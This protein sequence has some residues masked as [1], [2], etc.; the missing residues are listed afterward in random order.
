VK[1]FHVH[2]HADDIETSVK[3]YTTLFGA[4][5]TKHKPDYAKWMLD[6]PRVN[7]AISKVEGH[8]GLSH[9]GL[10]VDDEETLK[11]VS[12]VARA[13]SGEILVE[14]QVHCGYAMGNKTWVNDPQAVRWEN[15]HT[16]DDEM[17]T[18]GCGAEEAWHE[19]KAGERLGPGPSCPVKTDVEGNTQ[20]QEK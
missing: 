18:F 4:K 17:T 14:R 13:A 6:D 3:F 16:Y 9:L 8:V 10:Q 11:D 7:F 2:L 20:R 15:F 1:R 12:E 5:P 19:N